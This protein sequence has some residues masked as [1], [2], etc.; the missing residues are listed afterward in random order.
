MA[1]NAS[2]EK[3]HRQSLKRRDHNRKFMSKMRTHLKAARLAIEEKSENAADIVKKAAST[4]DR[5]A[6]KGVIPKKTAARTISRLY[7]A[8]GRKS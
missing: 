7:L 2:A 5:V 1:N 6:Q 3:R 8:L 4:L